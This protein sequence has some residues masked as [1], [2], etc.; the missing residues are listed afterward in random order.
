MSS[1]LSSL[2][3][4]T[5]ILIQGKDLFSSGQQQAFV[6]ALRY[7]L[8]PTGSAVLGVDYVTPADS[9]EPLLSLVSPTLKEKLQSFDVFTELTTITVFKGETEVGSASTPD[10]LTKLL[11]T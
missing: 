9:L 11:E 4:P 6:H 10:E 2:E 8:L 3:S 7:H 1:V 5:T